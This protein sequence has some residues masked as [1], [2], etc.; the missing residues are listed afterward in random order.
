MKNVWKMAALLVGGMAAASAAHS[1]PITIDDGLRGWYLEDGSHNGRSDTNNY[2]TENDP[3]AGVHTRNWFMFDLSGI[4]MI[5]SATFRIYSTNYQG[6]D[7]FESYHLFDVAESPTTIGDSSGASIFDDLGSG[8]WYGWSNVTR[9]DIGSYIEIDLN[10]AGVEAINRALGFSVVF[11]G[12]V[13][14]FSDISYE[15]I[16]GAS[17]GAPGA[18]LVVKPV[19]EPATL[20]LM[21]AGLAGL[22]ASRR[23]R[24][25]LAKSHQTVG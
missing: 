8:T 16:F 4:P 14:S 9:A 2:A 23:L 5:A 21:L 6:S 15:G 25:G 24:Q 19:P 20:M 17:T 18:E 11:G 12:A 7:L 3:G 10:A 1:T 22:L 13:T